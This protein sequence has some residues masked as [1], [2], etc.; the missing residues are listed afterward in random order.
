MKKNAGSVKMIT[1]FMEIAPVGFRYHARG[2][3]A[4]Y[5]LPENTTAGNT[6]IVTL[7]MQ[8]SL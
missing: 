1:R 2:A 3:A 7:V 8:N 6:G 5:L 4:R